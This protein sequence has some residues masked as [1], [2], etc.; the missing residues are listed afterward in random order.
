MAF[1][2]SDFHNVWVFRGEAATIITQYQA[3]Y[4][5]VQEYLD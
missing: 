2:R 5:G 1:Q 4:P 3:A